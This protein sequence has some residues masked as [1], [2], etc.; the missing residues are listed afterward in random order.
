LILS[1]VSTASSLAPVGSIAYVPS[2]GGVGSKELP[3]WTLYFAMILIRS[4]SGPAVAPP[5]PNTETRAVLR[6][7]L[8]IEA[9]TPEVVEEVLAFCW[10]QSHTL[11]ASCSGLVEDSKV[12]PVEPKDELNLLPLVPELKHGVQSQAPDVIHSSTPPTTNSLHLADYI[13]EPGSG[14]TDPDQPRDP[15]PFFPPETSSAMAELSHPHLTPDVSGPPF[16]RSFEKISGRRTT[17]PI[18]LEYGQVDGVSQIRPSLS[19]LKVVSMESLPLGEYDFSLLSH[20]PP[21]PPPKGK[22]VFLLPTL[23]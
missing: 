2:D 21:P 19:L 17:P 5:P 3:L 6:H 20:F 16:A 14:V 1:W 9:P 11:L 13:D 4:C 23:P 12:E 7:P 18:Q 10:F 8:M 15:A 22:S